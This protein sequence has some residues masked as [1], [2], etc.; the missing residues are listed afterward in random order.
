MDKFDIAPE[1]GLCSGR[2][3]S[4]W[5]PPSKQGG[6]SKEERALR[7][8]NEKL[9]KET[10]TECESR[11]HCLEYSLRHEPFGTW[12]GLNEVE[13]AHLRN[14]MGI[15]LSR[16]GRIILPGVGSMNAAT[17]SI[18]YKKKVENTK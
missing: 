7:V 16:E 4:I 3:V 11:I 8:S 12:G 17:G 1:K 6:L 2:D 9:A 18:V 5:F 14:R 15:N 10:C 13:R